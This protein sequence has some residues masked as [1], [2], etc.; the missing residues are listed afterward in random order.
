MYDL[1]LDTQKKHTFVRVA[2]SKPYIF[3]TP[4]LQSG[5]HFLTK[6]SVK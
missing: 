4:L 1:Q 5:G 2:S 3:S 6:K